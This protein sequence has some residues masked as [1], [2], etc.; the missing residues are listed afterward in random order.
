MA[1]KLNGK[2]EG[3]SAWLVRRSEYLIQDRWITVRADDCETVD[4]HPVTPYYVLEY[5]DWVHLAVFDTA[6]RMMLVRLYRHGNREISL[7]IPGGSMDPADTT[8]EETARRELL[9]ETGYEIGT[10]LPLGC[11]TPN[12]ATH[13]NRMFP[14]AALDCRKVAEP[15]EDPSER[16]EHFFVEPREVLGMI[17]SGEFRQ[18]L[19]IATIH[20]AFQ[21]LGLIRSV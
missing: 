13:N 11:L 21:K 18:A 2:L 16:I 7:E 1:K 3:P 15:K 8:P 17:E 10:L 14:F 9:E 4:G 6:G 20:M 19:H 12:S 5:G